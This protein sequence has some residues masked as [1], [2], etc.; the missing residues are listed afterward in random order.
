MADIHFYV[1]EVPVIIRLYRL[2]SIIAKNIKKSNFKIQNLYVQHY[3][4]YN[5]NGETYGN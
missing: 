1:L 5:N 4:W 3:T 2:L